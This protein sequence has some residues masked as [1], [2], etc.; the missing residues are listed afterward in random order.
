MRNPPR[1]LD[2]NLDRNN[3]DCFN[4]AVYL[5][6]DKVKDCTAYDVDEG[7]IS[8]VALDEK[9]KPL[10]CGDEFKIIYKKGRVLAAWIHP[11]RVL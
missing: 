5:D 9:G 11:E 6:G 2:A 7:W 3:P 1:R 8:Q 10:V 4:I